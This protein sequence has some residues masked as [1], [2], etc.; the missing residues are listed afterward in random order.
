MRNRLPPCPGVDDLTTDF[1]P[2]D[3]LGPTVDFGEPLLPL[4]LI[5]L[6]WLTGLCKAN[7][8]AALDLIADDIW[9]DLTGLD[10]LSAFATEDLGSGDL[11]ESALLSVLN[12]KADG[13]GR[14][15]GV[16]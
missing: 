8:L 16:W 5:E 2:A 10:L 3:D 7:D 4:C 12:G 11:L 15:N 14:F 9:P 1:G 13:R 6:E